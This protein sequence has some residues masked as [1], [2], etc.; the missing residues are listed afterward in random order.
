MAKLE[1]DGRKAELLLTMQSWEEME[2]EVGLLDDF[3]ELMTGRERLKN[4]RLCAEV[5]SREGARQGKGEE[6]PADWLRE[7]MRPAQVRLLSSAIRL[8]VTE[9]MRMETTKGEDQATDAILA[10]IEKKE[11]ADA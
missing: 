7:H 3:D 2:E 6:L 10:K 8:A 9:G 1:I 4:M 11:P 5:L